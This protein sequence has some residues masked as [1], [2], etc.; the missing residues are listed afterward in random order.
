MPCP[1]KPIPS[2]MAT[3]K[4][5]SNLLPKMQQHPIFMAI[6]II[7]IIT[8]I[9]IKHSIKFIIIPTIIFIII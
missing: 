4:F 1:R 6:I 8:V 5:P 3:A 9:I 7:I 2:P